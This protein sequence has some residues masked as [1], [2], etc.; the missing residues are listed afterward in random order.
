MAT[1]I[2]KGD[3]LL[4]GLCEYLATCTSIVAIHSSAGKI[5]VD[6]NQCTRVIANRVYMSQVMDSYKAFHKVCGI[7]EQRITATLKDPLGWGV[8]IQQSVPLWWYFW[9]VMLCGHR[10]IHRRQAFS[11][12][13]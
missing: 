3:Q 5:D 12:T 10:A 6:D 4:V 13:M 8:L 9:L 7:T 1:G 2:F 11:R